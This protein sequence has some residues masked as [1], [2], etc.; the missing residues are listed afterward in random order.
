MAA[1]AGGLYGSHLQHKDNAL[2]L[3]LTIVYPCVSGDLEN[4]A[5][6]SSGTK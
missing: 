3:E 5:H 1:E 2:L 4:A 6:Q